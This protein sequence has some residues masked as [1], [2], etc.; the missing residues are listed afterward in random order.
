MRE[1]EALHQMDQV[2][3]DKSN[4]NWELH[5]IGAYFLEIMG[6]MVLVIA[7]CVFF[8]K[9]NSAKAFVF[10]CIVSTNMGF[11]LHM[12]PY[13]SIVVKEKPENQKI[14]ANIVDYLKYLP[15]SSENIIKD[16]MK[17]GAKYVRNRAILAYAIFGAECV[18]YGRFCMMALIYVTFIVVLLLVNNFFKLAPWRKSWGIWF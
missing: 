15:I 12:L 8:E 4:G 9:D 18:A 11:E 13:S 5:K 7:I 6:Y 1:I 3:K 10:S 16:R 2:I 17:I 14:T